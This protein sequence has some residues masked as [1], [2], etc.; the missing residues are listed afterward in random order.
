VATAL[1][2]RLSLKTAADRLEDAQRGVKNARNRLLPELDLS[3]S[4]GA[5]NTPGTPARNLNADTLDYSAGVT[6]NLPIDRVSERNAYR[7]SLIRFQQ[8]QRDYAAAKDEIAIDVRA[9]LR[10]IRAAEVSVEI[11]RQNLELAE[12]RL[13]FANELLKQGKREARDVVEAQSALLDAQD[14]YEGAR[15]ELQVQV[16]QFMRDTG[17]LRVDPEAG[18]IGRAMERAG[19]GSTTSPPG[20]T[21]GQE[22]R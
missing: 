6:L 3:A 11:Q 16:L 19:G 10:S 18:A 5:G 15:R 13:E 9:A 2:Y 12:R 21:T 1:K 7:A 4:V 22:A 14:G 8:V 20:D 17:T